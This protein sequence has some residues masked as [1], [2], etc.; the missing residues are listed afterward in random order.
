VSVTLDANI[1][2]YAS[3]EASPF[4]RRALDLV[5][6]LALGPELFYVF[7]PTIT[8]YLRIATHAAIF[9]SP[10]P[11][12]EAIANVEQLLALPHVQ[13]A[14]EQPRFW[15]RFREIATDAGVRGNLVPDAHLVALM[16]ENGVRTLWTHDRDFRRFPGI[17]VRD[18]FAR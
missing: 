5:R 4:H 18:P 6:D 13:T 11:P 14:G 15:Q 16:A 1:L 8:A 10:L 9:E 2:L 3:D 7:W 12:G 17:D